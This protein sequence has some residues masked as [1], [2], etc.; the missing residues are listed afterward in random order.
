MLQLIY[1]AAQSG[2][3]SVGTLFDDL[4]QLEIFNSEDSKKNDSELGIG[5]RCEGSRKELQ[6]LTGRSYLHAGM[7][8]RLLLQGLCI[9]LILLD[10]MAQNPQ[11]KNHVCP[12]NAYS[13]NNTYC[14]CN[15]GFTSDS[16][17]KFFKYEH[18]NCKDI[19]ECKPPISEDCGPHAECQN[20]K[21]SFNC[22]CIPGYE[23]LSG[24]V[25][26]KNSSSNT[27][28]ITTSS[29]EN[30]GNKKLEQV[31][32][33]VAQQ[34]R[35]N[36]TL[37]EKREKKEVATKITNILLSMEN[38]VLEAVL[39]TP[40]QEIQ[41][42]ENMS[43]AVE[44]RV[45]RDNCSQN[46]FNLKAHMNSMEIHC[47][48]INQEKNQGPSAVAFI[49]YASLG[50]IINA[51]FFKEMSEN[52]QVYLNSQIVSAATRPKR[53][54]TL[55]EPVI[56]TF[57]H[58][59]MNRIF[60]KAFCVYWDSTE[61]GSH[62]SRHGCYVMH[63]NESHTVCNST[64]LSSFAVLMAITNQEE[65]PVLVV[66]TYVGLSLS[67]LCLFLA[68]LTFLLCKTIQNTST[69]IHLQL[70]ICLFLAHL[71]F[72]T[73]IDKTEIKVLCAIIAGALHYLYLASFTWMLLEGLN[74]FLTAHNL[75]VVN[76]SNINKFMKWF[77]FPVGYGVPAVIVAVSAAFK[78]H[79]YGTRHHCWLN[80]KQGFIWGF[81][82]PVCAII[83]V[84]F[85]F[86]SLVL[87]ILKKN[88]CSLNSE[89]STIQ[90]I[91]MLTFKAAAQLFILGC[92]WILG[93]LQ[94]GPG[95]QVMAYLFTIINSLQGVFIFLVYCILNQ[96][97]QKWIREI[98]K[99]KSKSESYTLSSK[100]GSD[101][102]PEAKPPDQT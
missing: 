93:I 34:I 84:N 73:A 16:G 27:C 59:E 65:D 44:T 97:V 88:L 54:T 99:H 8:G 38:N 51:T 83:C 89:V 48:E 5:V 67:L 7:Q 1:K 41:E 2:G 35:K 90:N 6:E 64:H 82:G 21:G 94:V 77:M 60:D 68:A 66:I 62:W 96:Q 26:F 100:F 81:L 3:D 15:P 42:I 70:S 11:A 79:L 98:I 49:S 19:D 33:S 46:I 20:V 4:E 30:K 71:L 87:C 25:L 55:S 12:L 37:W 28:N 32:E 69:S 14:T 10:F 102:K 75:R 58:T 91:R 9:L 47:S 78:S 63:V 53:N 80:V 39:K 85:V 24:G 74:L 61:E 56:L 57:Q 22:K 45:V 17:F 92:T 13:V 76:Y 52:D 29:G 43:I 18:E 50:H 72:L 36:M 31:I 40:E 23:L 86:F 95:A 101:S